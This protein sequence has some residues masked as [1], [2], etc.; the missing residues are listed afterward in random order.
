[1]EL[2]DATK[3]RPPAPF[4]ISAPR[5]PSLRVGEIN[6]IIRAFENPN[7]ADLVSTGCVEVGLRVVDSRWPRKKREK[8]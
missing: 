2:E 3:E 7:G 6:V 5:P 4:G 8:K 1:M